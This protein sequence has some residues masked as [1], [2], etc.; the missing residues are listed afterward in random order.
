MTI[1]IVGSTGAVGQAILSVLEKRAFPFHTL[2]CFASSQSVGKSFSFLGKEIT[3]EPLTS[4]CFQGIDL[5]FFAAGSAVSLQFA[6]EAVS[7]GCL[8]IDSSS[9]FRMDP[10]V[11]L[12]IPEINSYALSHHQGIIA[13]PNCTATMALMTLFPL[14]KSAPL[15]RVVMSTYQAASGA[16]YQGMQHLKEETKA[17]LNQ[18]PFSSNV[19]PHP[20]AFN[21]FPHNAPMTA[22]RYNEEEVKV[23]EESRKILQLPHL[24]MGVTCVR[25]PVMRAHSLSINVE[26]T[27]GISPEEAYTVLAT[28]P[29]ITVL[30]NWEENRFPMPVDASGQDAVFVG[31]IRQDLSQENALD[32]WVVGDQLLKGA[33]LNAV[34]IAEALASF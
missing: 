4:S 28:S 23:M 6:K 10:V 27:R 11:P 30:E 8:V 33:A 19:F 15:K 17:F 9:A 31:R 21:L 12:V 16:G 34:Q 20:Y 29:G 14:H 1:A 2:K 7:Q 13:S 25:V 22:S 3:I 32:L 18:T 26:F 5:A 24:K